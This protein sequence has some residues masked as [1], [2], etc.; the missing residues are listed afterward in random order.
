VTAGQSGGG[1][2]AG[3]VVSYLTGERVTRVEPLA[4]TAVDSPVARVHLDGGPGSYIVKRFPP[5]AFEAT[6]TLTGLPADEVFAQVVGEDPASRAICYADA[7][8]DTMGDV[9]RPQPPSG[10]AELARVY[11]ERVAAAH[12]VLA[13]LGTVPLCPPTIAAILGFQPL[14]PV[15]SQAHSL[16]GQL[17]LLAGDRPAQVPTQ[18]VEAAV[19]AERATVARMWNHRDGRRWILADSNPFNLVRGADNRWRWVDVGAVPG[20]PETNLMALGGA[21]FGLSDGEVAQLVV[22]GAGV[23]DEPGV[24]TVNGLFSLLTMLD[25]WWG[26]VAG[27]RDG[28][29]PY[30]WDY[31]AAEV[32]SL[33]VAERSVAAGWPQAHGLL[34][35]IRWLLNVPPSGPAPA[36]GGTGA[37][38]GSHG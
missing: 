1:H 26:T 15:R 32:F 34:G 35:L 11:L 17:L 38:G 10:R 33:R 7:G 2:W 5:G 3:E 22:S 29:A 19:A 16:V 6:R 12:G 31:S 21:A 8:Q 36:R 14:S 13:R 30:G 18:V 4:G 24:R 27:V 37:A 23:L 20:L 28:A 9:L 25:T